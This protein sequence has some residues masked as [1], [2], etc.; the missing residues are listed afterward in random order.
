MLVGSRTFSPETNKDGGLSKRRKGHS[1]GT[2]TDRG[3][4][5]SPFTDVQTEA[6]GGGL[7]KDEVTIRSLEL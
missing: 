5:L 7:P 1:L 6:Q 2:A 4:F 3:C